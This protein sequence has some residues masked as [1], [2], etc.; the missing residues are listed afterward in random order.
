MYLL[1]IND[2]PGLN[3]YLHLNKWLHTN[4]VV[5]ELTVPGS[6]NMNCVLRLKTNLANTYII[7]QSKGYVE[8]YPQVPAPTNRVII[9]A[10]FYQCVKNNAFLQS[11]MPILLQ[12]DE[13]NNCILLQ[14]LGQATDYNFLYDSSQKLSEN[15]A[16]Q[17]TQY[18]QVLHQMEFALKNPLLQNIEMKKL[19]HQYIFDHPLQQN[20]G[21]DLDAITPGLRAI[22]APYLSDTLFK[23]KVKQ[24]GTQYL[25]EGTCLLHGDYYPGSWLHTATGIKIIDPEFCFFGSPEFDLGVMLAH[26]YLSAQPQIIIDT[27]TQHYQQNNNFNNILL[28]QYTGIEILRRIV[29]LAQLPI[30]ATLQQKA[31][32]LQQSY[33]LINQ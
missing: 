30:N 11:G 5:T 10:A 20:N 18:L 12:L 4:E 22:A 16:I 26:C 15:E 21:V 23:Q 24:L 13:S 8:K 14:D 19:N 2:I 7:K 32:L 9:E 29:G 3:Q 31:T 17:L 28:Q 6:G 25:A 33:N 1:H 27:I